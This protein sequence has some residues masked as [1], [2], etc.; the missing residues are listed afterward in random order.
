MKR[1]LLTRLPIIA[2]VILGWWFWQGGGGFLPK[3]RE[4]V[5]RLPGEYGS[6]R[7]VELQVWDGD[8]LLKREELQTPK[9]LM[10]DPTQKL[11]VGGGMIKAEALVWREGKEQPEVFK[12]QRRLS[13]ESLVV[14]SL[15]GR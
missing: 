7:K 1:R 8:T 12:M 9:G 5:W 3:E 11:A 13:D 15:S 10:T 14:I 4:F 2:V 6:I